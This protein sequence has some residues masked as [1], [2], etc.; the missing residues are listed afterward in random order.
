M[1]PSSILSAQG[2]PEPNAAPIKVM[3]VDDAVVVRGLI[4][5]WL[6]DEG[7]FD[8]VATC[9]GALQALE[10]LER[11]QPDVIVLDIEMPE[12][13][14]LTALPLILASRPEVGIIV[15][16]SLG[17]TQADLTLRCLERGAMDF[18]AKPSSNRDVTTSSDFRREMVQRI[19]ALGRR[20]QRRSLGSA[21]VSPQLAVSSP[22]AAV[23]LVATSQPKAPIESGSGGSESPP[24][25]VVGLN[26]VIP[27]E[28]RSPAEV[29][30][31]P[32]F[33]LDDIRSRLLLHPRVSTPDEVSDRPMPIK[34]LPPSPSRLV[35]R[36][37]T[38]VV[39][40]SAPS[41]APGPFIARNT[42]SPSRPVLPEADLPVSFLEATQ[43][44]R[45]SRRPSILVIGAS[46]G[47]PSAVLALLTE[48]KPV[49][50]RIPVVVVQH[51]PAA[52]TPIFA[53]H[54]RRHIGMD[55]HEMHDR[56]L[57]IPGSVY[58]AP[59]GRHLRLTG[60]RGGIRAGLAD[61]APVNFSKPSVDVLFESAAQTLGGAVIGVV[62]TGMGSD[63]AAGAAAIHAA[64]GCI[65]AQD[66]ASSVVWG[67]PGA[68]YRTGVCQGVGTAPEIGAMVTR[69]IGLEAV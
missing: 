30:Q 9:R 61:D 32:V 5:R 59:G 69:F 43:P 50:R 10:M 31:R 23:R 54:V 35:A 40:P 17:A 4:S 12:L 63:G 2:A 51:M 41:P 44:K 49:I 55:A 28:V 39:P 45:S 52:F 68:V 26:G 25:N 27:A 64:G 60:Q 33:T 3:V 38:P 42:P 62:L 57:V 11:A 29:R 19:A 56:E 46:T 34:E 13:D 7:G 24:S 22:P 1:G 36:H 58:I 14:G 8:V 67:M 16:S 53:E 15:T 48:I 18:I 6:I 20:I 21:N 47:G 65:F 37:A 66:E